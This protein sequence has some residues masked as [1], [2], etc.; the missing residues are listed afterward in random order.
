MEYLEVSDKV[1]GFFTKKPKIEKGYYPAQLRSVK[2]YV[3]AEDKPIE[4]TFGRMLIFEFAIFKK[5]ISGPPTEPITITEDNRTDDLVMP[6]FVYY[7]YKDKKTGEYQTAITAN[8]KGITKLLIALGWTFDSKSKVDPES[9]VGRWV[10]VNI[11]DWETE[12]AKGV[13]Y[14]AS[15]IKD[16]GKYEGEIS[17]ISAYDKILC[18]ICGENPCKKPEWC[19]EQK[20]LLN[21]DSI[22]EEMSP[23]DKLEQEENARIQM[24]TEYKTR[25]DNIKKQYSDGMITKAGFEMAIEQLRKKYK[26]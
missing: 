26:I 25:S 9:F 19:A 1:G 12:D 7:Q 5:P 21:G 23:L 20:I 8:S 24:M 4:G 15:T 3:D 14:K 16:I 13:K 11:D 2:K 6:K 10:E 22:P 17:P 18:V